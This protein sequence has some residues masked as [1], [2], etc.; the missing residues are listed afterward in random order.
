MI[1]GNLLMLTCTLR[2]IAF[3]LEH[4]VILKLTFCIVAPRC[5]EVDLL[6]AVII[7]QVFTLG[8]HTDN[9]TLFRAK[10]D[11]GVMVDKAADA[12]ALTRNVSMPPAHS[13][14]C[15]V[16]CIVRAMCC[17]FRC[18]RSL[19]CSAVSSVGMPRPEP[20]PRMTIYLESQVI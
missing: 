6:P 15:R 1:S 19:K 18:A 2:K 20:S 13:R 4:Y 7:F 14:L 3:F 16:S 12:E 9:L 8:F 10:D 17:W 5:A 11:V